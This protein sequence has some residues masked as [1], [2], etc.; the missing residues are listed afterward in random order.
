MSKLSPSQKRPLAET[1]YIEHG[2]T[3][4]QIC[5]D[6]I[7]SAPTLSKWKKGRPGEKDWDTRRAEFLASPHKIKELLLSQL[8]LVAE[9]AETTIDADAL[10]KISKVIEAMS[11]KVSTQVVMSVFMEFDNWMASQDPTTAVKFTKWHKQF[12][13]YKASIE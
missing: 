8:Q 7:L 4:K 10:S 2:L 5:E 9:G 3:A 11:D 1:K 6:L 13:L 12:I